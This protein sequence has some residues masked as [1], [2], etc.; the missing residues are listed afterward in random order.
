MPSF[1]R[2]LSFVKGPTRILAKTVSNKIRAG[3]AVWEMSA[4]EP[5]HV[6]WVILDEEEL[7]PAL[8]ELAAQSFIRGKRVILCGTTHESGWAAE[9]IDAGAFVA[10]L[11]PVDPQGRLLVGEGDRLAFRE[12]RRLASAE[13]RKLIR[14]R[15]GFKGLYLAGIHSATH[16]L[17]P[18]AAAAVESFRAAGI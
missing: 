10:T 12:L 16:L 11:N 1:L 18:C 15:A 14:L 6:I 3:T 5:C 4:L 2:S 17:L 13:G 9:L 8:V 7:R